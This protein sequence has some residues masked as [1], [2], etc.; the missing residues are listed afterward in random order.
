M[1]LVYQPTLFD[2][3]GMLGD[4]TYI[5][6][7]WLWRDREHEILS[8]DRIDNWRSKIPYRSEANS[9]KQAI[10][11]AKS[12]VV[13]LVSAPPPSVVSALPLKPRPAQ[14]SEPADTNLA[15]LPPSIAAPFPAVLEYP[16]SA[17]SRRR[18]GGPF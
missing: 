13:E 1:K 16:P 17:R 5:D 7:V 4:R 10:A 15:A 14:S 9:P 2:L 18:A 6:F 3:Q 8:R 12:P 11:R